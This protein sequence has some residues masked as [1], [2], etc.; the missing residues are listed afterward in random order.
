[1]LRSLVGSEMCIRDRY[2]PT[3]NTCDI[4]KNI[5]FG[6]TLSKVIVS[7]LNQLPITNGE[8]FFDKTN[9]FRQYLSTF[10]EF[11]NVQ[12]TLMF[13]TQSKDPANILLKI[14]SVQVQDI[15]NAD[16]NFESTKAFNSYASIHLSNK[17]IQNDL[18]RN[19]YTSQYIKESVVENSCWYSLII[20]TYKEPMEKY[21]KKGFKLT[22]ETLHQMLF[23][24]TEL[25]GSNN[26]ASYKDVLPFFKKYKLA[27]C[28]FDYQMN[29]ITRFEPDNNRNKDISPDIIYV[30]HHNNHVFKLNNNLKS[31]AITVERCSLIIAEPNTHYY[32][33]KSKER[34]CR[35]INDF[36]GLK[37]IIE[38]KTIEG[39]VVLI[40][41]G[42]CC[43]DLWIQVYEELKYEPEILMKDNK[44][45]FSN[46]RL[47]NIN[48]KNIFI[49]VYQEEGVTFANDEIMKNEAIFKNYLNKK[50][51]ASDVLISKQYLSHYNYE[52][53]SM[54]KEYSIGPLVGSF[55]MYGNDLPVIEN[56][57]NKYYTSIYNDLEYLPVVNAFDKFVN[58]DNHEIEK[59][60]LYYVGKTNGLYEYPINDFSL[61]FGINLKEVQ[62]NIISYLR[63]S[64]LVKN[65]A[66]DIINDIYN[67]GTLTKTMRKNIINH[68]I[69]K[70]NK[71][72]N[73]KFNTQLFT[74]EEECN[75]FVNKYEG[76]KK[77]IPIGIDR[78]LY[79]NYI[80]KK[81]EMTEGFK[82]IS[83]LIYDI[84]RRKLLDL[85]TKFEKFGFTVYGCNTDAL[86]MNNDHE[87][88]EQFK[89]CNMDMYDDKTR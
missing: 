70:L 49:E 7:Q 67:D 18:L 29:L 69:G 48:G 24:D 2:R 10:N 44:I 73:T 9:Y 89:E 3:G 19:A 15:N 25:K 61:C 22:Y 87:L 75:Y 51:N 30:V 4:F 35:I 81:S 1:M 78:Y 83:Y 76:V 38:D 21:Y 58:Y 23:P 85:K 46:M 56:D 65:N 52:V 74:S 34:E 88:F 64:K 53:E 11:E 6:T 86:Y 12:D 54:L 37:A 17:Y 42:V 32:L 16:I 57:F 39:D 84:A 71:T 68:I 14:E 40:Y 66:S 60:T 63:P 26:G 33:G 5:N 47:Q 36:D 43:K 79:V 50:G 82:L 31:L 59:Y 72:Y 20:D 77:R 28:L 13:I 8:E 45:S 80:E 41:N 62:C 55:D 27:V